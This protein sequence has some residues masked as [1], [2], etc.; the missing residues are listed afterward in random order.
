MAA[1][2][3]GGPRTFLFVPG[4][5]PDR[6]PKALNSAADCV[7]VDLEDSVAVSRK[8][9]ARR[10]T[11]EALTQNAGA[12][13]VR[14]AVR[15]NGTAS[16]LM[17]EDVA[18]LT[19]A[20]P[21]LDFIVLPMAD[22]LAVREL[23][24]LTPGGPRIIPLIETAQGVV[25][26]AAIATADPRVDRLAFGPADLSAQLGLT[27]TAEGQELL[28]ARSQLVLASAAAELA[29]PIDGPWLDLQN[30][31][32]LRTST[33]QAR[34]LGF[35]AK[36]VLHPRQIG[37]VTEVLAP[38]AEELA[39]ARAVDAAFTEAERRGVAS[40]QLADGTFVDY[41]VARRARALLGRPGPVLS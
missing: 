2:P 38:T 13:R 35:G 4:D 8:A 39:W 19:G 27:L 1:D 36:Q 6:I 29:P 9:E 12:G 15:V 32:G 25:S 11:A 30:E 21:H 7:I 16:G 23:V 40:I 3:A 17:A 28:V 37:P 20:W 5:R 33:E 41:P 10:S 14:L 22:V 34:R 24:R 26:A 18:G 31:A